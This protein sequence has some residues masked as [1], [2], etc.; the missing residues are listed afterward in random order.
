MLSDSTR[1]LIAF[2]GGNIMI[3]D[4]A[5]NLADTKKLI[6]KSNKVTV[7]TGAGISTESG[8]PDYRSPG[9]VWSRHKEV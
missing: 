8:I 1:E 5:L 3:R 2:Y 4:A 9:G 6:Q 7:L